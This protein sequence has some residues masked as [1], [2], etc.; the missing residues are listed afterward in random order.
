MDCKHC[1]TLIDEYIFDELSAED[2]KEFEEVLVNCS[3]CQKELK[4]NQILIGAYQKDIE[5]PNFKLLHNN[6]ITN[7]YKKNKFRKL[8]IYIPAIAA[9]VILFIGL[10]IFNQKSDNN[11]VLITND[12]T[13]IKL[14]GFVSNSKEIKEKI[15]LKDEKKST[16]TNI[17]VS[18]ADGKVNSIERDKDK[19]I[20]NSIA[21]NKTLREKKKESFNKDKNIIVAKAKTRRKRVAKSGMSKKSKKKSR[22][23]KS[24]SKLDSIATNS[25]ETKSN[26][27]TKNDKSTKNGYIGK[28][29]LA[30]KCFR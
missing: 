13:N 5:K 10:S 1:E 30:T 7:I 22:A 17:K 6:I 27:S 3:D 28:K 26:K 19:I 18:K 11:I 15:A 12:T 21:L 23:Y 8:Y 29:N 16:G 2:K 4:E 9:T 25:F 20:K 24:D 14:E